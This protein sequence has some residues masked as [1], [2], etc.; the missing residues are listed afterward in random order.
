MTIST[1]SRIASA[2][3][4]RQVRSSSRTSGR[5]RSWR[6]REY[7]SVAASLTPLEATAP[8]SEAHR[9]RPCGSVRSHSR[10]RWISL[11]AMS[12]RSDPPRGR[13][14]D[15]TV[16]QCR[17]RGDGGLFARGPGHSGDARPHPGLDRFL[18]E[19]G[20]AFRDAHGSRESAGAHHA[21]ERGSRNTD[22]CQDVSRSQKAHCPPPWPRASATTQPSRRERRVAASPVESAPPTAAVSRGWEERRRESPARE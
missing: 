6:S 16:A 18:K 15:E 20:A 12:L 10:V 11:R 5:I 3:S 7:A 21:P 17:A 19:A 4:P 2:A 22:Q 8:S 14:A 13:D 1:L 9:P